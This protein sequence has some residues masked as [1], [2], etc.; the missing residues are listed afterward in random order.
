MVSRYSN[1]ENGILGQ[2]SVYNNVFDINEASYLIEILDDTYHPVPDGTVGHI[3]VTD[4]YNKARPFIR[5]DTGDM[6]A[7]RIF[8]I[9]GLQKRC[10]CDFSGRVLD[11]IYDC[12][13]RPCSPYLVSKA[14]WSFPD[15]AQFQFVQR[16]KTQYLLRLNCAP[17]SEREG[18]LSKAL[19]AIVGDE[20]QI[21][22]AYVSEIPVLHSGKRRYIVNEYQQA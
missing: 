19:R 17:D 21:D 7:V 9:G 8:E 10:I 14:M 13:G 4:L 3:V 2:D 15:I 18:R 20:A 22:F 16:G 11:V 1:E 6:G 12:A 5:Y